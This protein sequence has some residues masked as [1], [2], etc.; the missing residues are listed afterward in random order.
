MSATVPLLDCKTL[1]NKTRASFAESNQLVMRYGDAARHRHV[2]ERVLD[3]IVNVVVPHIG[4]KQVVYDLDVAPSTLSNAL[5][6][7]ERSK[8]SAEALIY[9][10][11]RSPTLRLLELIAG[12]GDALVEARPQLT[13]E[14]ELAALRDAVRRNVGPA[15]QAVIF[16]GVG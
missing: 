11:E 14:E 6:E 15:M 4:F 3:E 8:I 9:F 13:P 2:W 1:Q 10:V 12:V 16:E 7:R 5:R